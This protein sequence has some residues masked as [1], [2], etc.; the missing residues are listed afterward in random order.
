MIISA[1]SKSAWSTE[2]RAALIQCSCNELPG[3]RALLALG[4]CKVAALDM[5]T[6]TSS[7]LHS[8]YEMP[9]RCRRRILASQLVGF[10]QQERT[11]H[12]LRAGHFGIIIALPLGRGLGMILVQERPQY[13]SGD[14]T[15]GLNK[16]VCMLGQHCWPSCNILAA[17]T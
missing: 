10:D 4:S 16:L 14:W 12:S 7:V 3:E 2:G 6:R 15:G 9:R 13:Q 11:S 1:L 5:H 8:N 17:W